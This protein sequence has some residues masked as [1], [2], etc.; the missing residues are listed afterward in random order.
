MP[1]TAGTWPTRGCLAAT[2]LRS[3]SASGAE[4]TMFTG[5]ITDVGTIENVERRGD[6]R[7]RIASGYDTA[8]IELGASIA[9]S[10]VC[11]TVVD[12]GPGWF[13]VDISGET[14]SKT[15]SRLWE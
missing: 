2:G 15:A 12:K 9:C 3:T 8:T 5:I 1:M 7:A 6:L 13:E 14:V 4:T 10:G 11:L